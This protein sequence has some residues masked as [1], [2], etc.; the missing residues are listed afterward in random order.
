MRNFA[1]NCLVKHG[2]QSEQLNIPILG[3]RYPV[4]FVDFANPILLHIL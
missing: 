3:W 2:W 1:R 4:T